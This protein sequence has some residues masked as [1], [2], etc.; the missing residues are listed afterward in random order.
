MQITSR[1][2]L[3]ALGSQ[4]YQDAANNLRLEVF[5]DRPPGQ[6][7]RMA[8]EVA[9]PLLRAAPPLAYAAAWSAEW[10]R[11]AYPL[12][13]LGHVYAA[14]LMAT[15]VPRDI[16][17]HAPWPVFY[18]AVPAGLV[19]ILAR[20]GTPEDV[21][22]L[23]VFVAKERWTFLAPATTVEYSRICSELDFMRADRLSGFESEG[24]WGDTG[25][26]GLDSEPH[27][28]RAAL[29]LSRLLLNACVAMS[30]PRAVRQVGKAHR[31]QPGAPPPSTP[32]V[33]E[34]NRPVRV[35]CRDS[36]RGF[37]RGGSRI[38]AVQWLVRGHW[39]QQAH[40]PQHAQRRLTWIEPYWKGA[41]GAPLV[42]HE[43][44]LKGHGHDDN[45]PAN[46]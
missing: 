25:T 17:I 35:D 43:H 1:E 9:S 28:D 34:L 26:Y 8:A 18:V 37:I 41:D 33:Y 32:R 24:P 45:Q 5:P 36:V 46:T 12:V 10:A 7:A 13:Q 19:T 21:T 42:M 4:L 38:P 27:D 16:D 30:D 40:G 44:Q 23:L 14:A 2:S 31:W 22:G 39:R 6:R 3:H 20:D 11:L 29:C 15:Q